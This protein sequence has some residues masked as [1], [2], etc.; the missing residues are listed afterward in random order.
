MRDIQPIIE[1]LKHAML[2]KLGDEDPPSKL[3]TH[4]FVNANGSEGC[5][6]SPV[7]IASPA[8]LIH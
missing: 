8:G 4:V 5:G 7:R 6:I 1:T 3:V 2:Q